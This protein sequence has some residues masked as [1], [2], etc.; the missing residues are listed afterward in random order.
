MKKKENGVNVKETT[1]YRQVKTT[2]KQNI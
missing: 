2:L 1:S